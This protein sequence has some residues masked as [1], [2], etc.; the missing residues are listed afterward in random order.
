MANSVVDHLVAVLPHVPLVGR[1][2]RLGRQAVRE[3]QVPDRLVEH[4]GRLLVEGRSR[5]VA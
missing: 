2:G 1:G 3:G 4:D 5:L